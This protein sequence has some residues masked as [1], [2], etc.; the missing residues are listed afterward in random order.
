MVANGTAP[1]T[2][3]ITV[4][5]ATALS[6]TTTTG[7]PSASQSYTVGGTNLTADVEV[8]SPSGYELA[9]ETT[10]GSGTP[11]TFSTY[12]STS[13][14]LLSQSSGTIAATTV[15]A[16]LAGTTAGTSGTSG[17][18]VN[19]THA[20]TGAT[21][22]SKPVYGTVTGP[23]ITGVVLTPTAVC[24]T[25][26][27]GSTSV[28]FTGNGTTGTYT[29]QLSD[30]AGSF[31][32]PLTTAT[33]TASPIGL[34]VPQGTA[35][36]TGYLVRV[37]NGTV[38]SGTA[39]LTVVN[40]PTVSIAPAGPQTVVAGSSGSLLT[41]T[42]S[43]A[44]TGRVWQVGSSA[45]G[46]FSNISPS[47]TG[48]SYTP[49]FAT[50]GTYFVRVLSTFAACGDAAS[51][52]VQVDV[53]NPAP[54]LT[55][56][57]PASGTTG[58]TTSVILTGTGFTVGSVVN[59]N[60]AVLTPTFNSATSLTVSLTAPATPG[61]YPVTVT[62]PTPGGGTSA[63]QNF[64]VT[65]GPLATYTAA[66]GNSSA[67]NL[68]V[69]TTATNVSATD[70]V[71]GSGART[72][73]SVLATYGVQLATAAATTLAGAITN[74]AYIE[75]TVST[76]A[77]YSAS[78]SDIIVNTYRT[79]AGPNTVAL[80]YSTN[81]AFL[82]SNQIGSS[83]AVNTSN[84]TL[85][86]STG[87]TLLQSQI[88]TVSYR[89]YIYN[90]AANGTGTG[91]GNIYLL[92]NGTKAITVNGIVTAGT[93]VPEINL[94]QGAT[95]IL[96]GTG[97]YGFGPTVVGNS[98][99]ATPF[100]IQNLGTAVLN[101]TGTPIVAITGNTADF[102][103]TQPTAATVAAGGSL[104]FTIAFAPTSTGT[105]TVSIS[106]AN[107]DSDEN[108]YT[109]TVTGTGVVAPV[110]TSFMPVT[111]PV[112]TVVTI[113]GTDFTSTATVSFN[114]T[115]ATAVTFNSTTSL[116]ATV[117]TG[118]T[119]GTITV[120]TAYG[121]STSTAIFTVT[122]TPTA[123]LLL[124]EDNF[125]YASGE[126]LTDHG[127]TGFSGNQ[128]TLVTTISNNLTQPQYPRGFDQGE[129]ATFAGS[130][131]VHLI[132]KTTSGQDVYRS[133]TP[134]TG[135]V[136]STYAA[137]V[138]KVNTAEPTDS[139]FMTFYNT[140]S[141]M[142][143]PDL[144]GRVFVQESGTGFKFGLSLGAAAASRY[145]S[146]VYS[147]NTQYLLVLK[148]DVDGNTNT[149]K[150]YVY[151]GAAPDAEPALPTLSASG[152][153][154]T[155]LGSLNSI[156]LRQDDNDVSVDGVRVATGWGAAI[157]RPIYVDEVTS[158]TAGNYYNLTVNGPTTRVTA[159]GAVSLEG[160]LALNGGN[161][162]TTATNSLTLYQSATISGG[163]AASFVNG[164]L[165]RVTG[166]GAATTV[167]PIGK[168]GAFRPLTLTATAQ[169]AITTYTAE[170]LEGNP[171]QAPVSAPVTRVSTK[172]SYTVTSS[173]TNPANFTGSITLT[174]GADDYV[175]V[176]ND[177]G[178]VI[179]KRDA[180]TANS[181][182][183]IGHSTETGGSG[184]G[185]GGAPVS[186]DITS[187]SF[188]GFSDFVL[189]ATTP[190]SPLNN[191]GSFLNPLPV[192]LAAFSAQRQADNLVSVKWYTASEKNSARF[193]LQRSLDGRDFATVA[194]VAA[195][196]SS[197][198]ATAYAFLDKAA[199]AAKL[200]Y[201][202][203]QIDLDGTTAFSPVITVAGTGE[204]A[205]MELYP[206]P[207][208]SHI[209]FIAAAATPYRVLNQL[210]QPLLHGTTEAGTA[211]V[212]VSA[213]PTGLYFLELQTATGRTVQKFE[214]E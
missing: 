138:V 108:P 10:P 204:T 79:T 2:P 41:A 165:A 183:S 178:L 82:V 208:H 187:N 119:T 7:T 24:T 72:V 115:A 146:T 20:S 61:V 171:G 112:G 126:N 27:A 105:K 144:R 69:S 58:S 17:M 147:R 139:Y 113:T 85:A 11:G 1:T 212:D 73:A 128:G 63:A 75:Y 74:N 145:T 185:V 148:Y 190:A 106:I 3:T 66:N 46:T 176:P 213:L 189:A 166:T 96:N 16:R 44:A 133:F 87:G 99:A 120:A 93:A 80:V 129:P 195:Q 53:T 127:W 97:S 109:F 174:F 102:V 194:V 198:H 205:K 181:W 163:S 37:I 104:P 29:V 107:N 207:A 167:F 172:R 23:T 45:T 70:G 132:G 121:S 26:G 89:L 90:I 57:A 157:G 30:A 193:E 13:P 94:A 114:G 59:F 50:A 111:G 156:A 49:N 184:S 175:N 62:N 209:S 48:I 153:V 117:P 19:I 125:A 18:P 81:G 86:F 135:T 142:A 159:N 5:P 42:E 4:T 149:A 25:S 78:V 35:S 28:A 39:A 154:S 116:T 32:T 84:T 170:Q 88:G 143:S 103:L 179:A 196:G 40:A 83:Q 12:P 91:G 65:A 180:A 192:E 164:P 191:F 31:T 55:G 131:T 136:A 168:G 150:L 177:A 155:S 8:V 210:G 134:S 9:L 199:P 51:N 76:A 173:S 188:S 202:L 200:Y 98:T 92:D 38:T 77:G 186:G 34:A 152:T 130:S 206:N 6:F 54:T 160:A 162:N 197:T 101:L 68:P 118:A 169:S 64:T 15:Y 95:T 140:L 33:G 21:S 141:G 123:G 52:P 56:I 110:V 161:I 151:S 47:Q 203:R 137:A 158:I 67:T 22:V 43:P 71:R 182:T 60:G 214:K 124:L 36:G 211:K 100:T 14:L 122:A 201:R